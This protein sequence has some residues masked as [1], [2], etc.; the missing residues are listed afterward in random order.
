MRLQ[1]IVFDLDGTLV[2]SL[3]GIQHSAGMAVSAV[4]PDCPIPDVRPYI[5]PPIWEG[6]CIALGAPAV[7]QVMELQRH[8]RSDYD[9]RGWKRTRCYPGAAELLKELNGR[10][11][12]CHVVTNKPIKPTRQIL[13]RLD[14]TALL[15][16]IVSKDSRMPVFTSKTEALSFLLDH[17]AIAPQGALMVGDSAD[18]AHAARACGLRFAAATYGYGEYNA[19]ERHRRHPEPDIKLT[20]L[21]DLISW[22]TTTSSI[23]EAT[24]KNRGR[25]S[26]PIRVHP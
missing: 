2:D 8:F 12:H 6:L 4:L 10:N 20:S 17:F 5:G 1:H 3:P 14:L 19:P 26:L 23:T 21:S 9:E 13:E 24:A 22:L 16:G 18:D 25:S 11:V 15:T 7:A